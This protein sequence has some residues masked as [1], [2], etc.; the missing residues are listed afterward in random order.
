MLDKKLQLKNG[1]TIALIDCPIRLQ[2]AAQQAEVH[3]ADAVL[4]FAANEAALRQKLSDIRVAAQDNKLVWV[5]YP[6]AKQLNTDLNRDSLR[7]L[8]N[9]NSLDPVRQVALDETW[10]ALRLKVLKD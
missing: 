2:L 4:L 1:Q 8:V 9:D 10:S 3:T 6:K 5:A 7:A